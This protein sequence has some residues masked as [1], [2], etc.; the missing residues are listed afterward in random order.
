MGILFKSFLNLTSLRKL[1]Y[2]DGK[3]KISYLKNRKMR[4]INSK[5]GSKLS[6]KWSI[7]KHA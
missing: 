6:K 1:F 3:F 2:S 4:Y 5:G 7:I